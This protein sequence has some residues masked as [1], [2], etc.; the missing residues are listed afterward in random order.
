MTANP[1]VRQDPAPTP[2]DPLYARMACPACAYEDNDETALVLAVDADALV[3]TA[4]DCQFPVIR[5]GRQEIPWSFPCP[6]TAHL[7][8]SARY[9]GEMQRLSDEHNRLNHALSNAQCGSRGRL[10][11]SVE[12]RAIRE[13]RQYLEEL[14]APIGLDGDDVVPAVTRN[15]RDKLPQHQGLASYSA[16]VFR[17]WSWNNGENDAQLR[18]VES[19]LQ[20]ME[21]RSCDAA[22][23][24]GAG[25]GRLA[26]D[27]HRR[28]EP[29]LSVALDFNP[30]LAILA[31]RVSQGESISLYEFPIAPLDEAHCAI[32]Q[33]MSAPE[34]VRDNSL[35]FVLGDATAPPFA[36]ASFDLV[37]TPWLLD[38][39]AQD[40]RTFLP[41]INRLLVDGGTWVNT[42]TLAFFHADP[43]RRYSE[44]EVLEL[45]EES[46]FEVDS[47]D[48]R[49]LPYL[50]S[51]HSG[52]GRTERVV[53]FAARKVRDV[54][55]ERR[56]GHL[57]DW[58]QDSSMSIP[59]T[60]TSMIDA[61]SQLLKAQVLAAIDGKRSVDDIALMVAREYGLSQ[62]ECRHAIRAML[63]ERS[64]AEL[65]AFLPW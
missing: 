44:A 8:W 14:L 47:L 22:L 26:Y 35:R 9:R 25:A 5:A 33:G 18:A 61:S 15:L 23:T 17:D 32:Q 27:M 48:C 2:D 59:G 42:G 1:E 36:P 40:L 29:S 56:R 49:T 46:G 41:Q 11:L 13:H 63:T 62:E 19:V 52:H 6:G 43:S 65:T 28:L 51:P 37:S 64:E 20:P 30:L 21:R 24:L 55:P 58:L 60:A 3:C 4:C 45:V 54:M 16:N 53:S 31:S 57:P 7:E 50:N 34:P 10:R 39:L 38:I 12:L